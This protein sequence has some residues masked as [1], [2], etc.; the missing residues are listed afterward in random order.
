MSWIKIT[1]LKKVYNDIKKRRGKLSNIMKIHSLN[2]RSMITHMDFY[3]SIMYTQ[4]EISR[5]D[6][7]L[8]ATAVSIINNC[9]YCKLHHAEALN[10]YWNN[11]EK[12]S[13]FIADPY[14]IDLSNKQ[15]SMLD[16]AIKLTK[17]AKSITQDDITNL[18]S[19]GLSDEEILNLNLITSYFN[20]VNRVAN[21]LNVEFSEEEITGYKY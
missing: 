8:I 14:S 20:F 5:E 3:T 6:R 9:E 19:N 21:G 17:N 1:N 11:K 15:K 12:L 4:H 2:P 7:E 16:Y 10:A 18:K 13:K